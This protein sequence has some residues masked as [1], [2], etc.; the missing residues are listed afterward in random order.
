MSE[1]SSIKEERYAKNS[2]RADYTEKIELLWNELQLPKKAYY[3]L[4]I[5]TTM[6]IV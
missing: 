2:L 4:F 3:S 1:K 6:Y 5:N